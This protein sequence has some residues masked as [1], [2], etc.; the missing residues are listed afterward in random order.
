MDEKPRPLRT[1]TPEQW[2]QLPAPI[3][4]AYNN[5]RR[6]RHLPPYDEP[7]I[8]LSPKPFKPWPTPFDLP[9]RDGA[10]P[11][12]PLRELA[13]VATR[14]E[15]PDLF[16]ELKAATAAILAAHDGE[17]RLLAARVQRGVLTDEER[18]LAADLLTKTKIRP[19]HRPRT[20][21]REI[22]E[23]TA[24]CLL[25]VWDQLPPHERKSQQTVLRTLKNGYGISRGRAFKILK[26]IR[27]CEKYHQPATSE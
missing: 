14:D 16:E 4:A 8:D 12:V 18:Y 10:I 9:R 2:A 3:R 26:A 20:L 22:A 24:E 7:A 11:S 27:E 6:Q 25:R 19:A 13:R 5:L 17:V 23:H 1:F 21:S 15:D